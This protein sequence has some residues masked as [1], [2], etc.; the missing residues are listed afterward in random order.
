MIPHFNSWSFVF[1]YISKSY[2]YFLELL[3]TSAE[4]I[5]Y[6]EC[7]DNYRNQTYIRNIYIKLFMFDF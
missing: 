7:K 3:A 2:Y 4:S 5:R 1:G 6:L